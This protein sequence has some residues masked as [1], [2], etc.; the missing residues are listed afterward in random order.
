MSQAETTKKAPKNLD[1]KL[2]ALLWPYLRKHLNLIVF[3]LSFV[4]LGDILSISL[5]FLTRHGIDVNIPAKDL[6]GLKVTSLIFALCLLGSFVFQFTSN[7]IIAFLGQKLLLA[8]RVDVFKKALS[9]SSDFYDKTPTGTIL[10]NVTNDVEA[11]RQFI[12]EGLV[13]VLGDLTK[14]VLI[15]VAMFVI[16]PWLGLGMSIGIPLFFFATILFRNS[17]RN[18]F[19]EVRSANSKI[20]TAMVESLN[21]HREI[22]LFQNRSESIRRFNGMNLDYL[23]AYRTVVTAYALYLPVIELVSQISMVIVLGVAHFGMGVS[24]KVGEIFAIF[25]FIGM[26]FRPLRDIAENFNTFQSAMAAM[27][28]IQKLLLQPLTITEPTQPV[29]LSGPFK[30]EIRFENVVFGYH[31]EKP[32]LKGISFVIKP[33]EKV[34]IVGST[35]AGKTT[36]IALLNRLYDVTSG[37]IKI[38]G[39]D[40]REY[41]TQDLRNRIATVPQDVFLFTGTVADN[42]RLYDESVSLAEVKKAAKAVDAASFIEK[43]NKQYDENVLEEGQSLSTGQKQLLS[44]ARAFVKNPSIIVLDEATSNIDSETEQVIEKSLNVL[45]SERTGIIIAHRLSTIRSV[46]RILVLHQGKLI[47]EG[48]HDQ[49]IKKNG[50]YQQLYQMQALSLG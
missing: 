28:R 9:L 32:V 7:F 2:M 11:V 45:L 13:S 14:V 46:D 40:L 25:M 10:T 36:M 22:A 39:V 1:F 24:V 23:N 34:A 4:L 18:G 31:P 5:P 50:L 29:S 42:I 15:L 26:F 6:H 8:L 43:L 47:E 16:N 35:G 33:G 37:S 19:R 20:N 38:D 21:G 41:A 30:G 48:S 44:F 17:I 12:S 3:G 49:L 27:E